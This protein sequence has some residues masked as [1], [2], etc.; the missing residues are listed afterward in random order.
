MSDE[1]ENNITFA[2]FQEL[3]QEAGI[4]VDNLG[5]LEQDFRAGTA[6]ADT[7]DALIQDYETRKEAYTA[8]DALKYMDIALSLLNESE[9]IA[10]SRI[11]AKKLAVYAIRYMAEICH[12]EGKN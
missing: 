4:S 1:N 2:E 9:D 10:A 7:T 3:C 11:Q 6:L 8:G 5:I 12:D